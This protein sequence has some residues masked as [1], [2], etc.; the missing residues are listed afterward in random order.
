MAWP[1]ALSPVR[2]IEELRRKIAS[3]Q[4]QWQGART[5]NE[6]L[7]KEVDELR[8]ERGQLEKDRDRLRGENEELKRRLEQALRAT[9][10]RRRRFPVAAARTSR[11]VRG[12]SLEPH[13]AGISARA[14][15]RRSTK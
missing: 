10:V 5:E 9:S 15:R 6:Q 13:T 8:Q 14:S 3:I 12:A 4:E 11:S 2:V 7:R 1:K